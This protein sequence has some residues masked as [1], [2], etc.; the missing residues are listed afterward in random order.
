MKPWGSQPTF[1]E[2]VHSVTHNCHPFKY[3]EK[4]P[5]RRIGQRGRATRA[6]SQGPDRMGRHD[7]G[8]LHIRD[9]TKAVNAPVGHAGTS[10]LSRSFFA[11]PPS[12][13]V[14]S[15]LH[16]TMRAA[17]LLPALTSNPSPG[18]S[19]RERGS[20]RDG[21]D[22]AGPVISI[23]ASPIRYGQPLETVACLIG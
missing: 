22:D 6:P 12:P 10:S 19:R 20:R 17:A 2:Y 23:R 11:S 3:N 13:S 21:S 14:T 16:S 9:G 18:L 8:L 1:S 15:G 5:G 7:A 4:R